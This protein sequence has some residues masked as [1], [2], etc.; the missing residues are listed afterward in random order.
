MQLVYYKLLLTKPI[1]IEGST[2][3]ELQCRAIYPESLLEN[4][5]PDHWRQ[6]GS[7]RQCLAVPFMEK[8]GFWAC[9]LNLHREALL[10]PF[11]T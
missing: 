11:C 6:G 10:R 7:G 8:C 9:T 5:F 4:G 2:S 1:I 3:H